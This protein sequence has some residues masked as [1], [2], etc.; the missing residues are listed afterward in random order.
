MSV[1]IS[2]KRSNLFVQTENIWCLAALVHDN[3]I[4]S[5]IY[6]IS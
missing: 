2:N 1:D 6:S 3:I 4:I 5:Q